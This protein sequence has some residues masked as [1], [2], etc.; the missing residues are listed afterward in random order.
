MRRGARRRRRIDYRIS[1]EARAP[2]RRLGFFGNHD[3]GAAAFRLYP[4]RRSG[5]HRIPRIA[6][7]AGENARLSYLRLPDR[8]RES[9]QL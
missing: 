7:P 6:P 3:G 2:S 9:V 1:G 8:Y 5:R 4:R